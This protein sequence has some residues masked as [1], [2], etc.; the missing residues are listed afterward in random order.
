MSN[1]S[2]I[3]LCT[4]IGIFIITVGLLREDKE[5]RRE[6]LDSMRQAVD[7]AN[8]AIRIMNEQN[9]TFEADGVQVDPLEDGRVKATFS[10][11]VGKPI[12]GDGETVTAKFRSV[13]MPA[14]IFHQ[15]IAE[16]S[17]K[18]SFEALEKREKAI[19]EREEKS[20]AVE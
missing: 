6:M 7:S 11:V 15:V 3:A 2:A 13:I 19:K 16:G 5:N 17:L 20:G 10:K 14:W 18:S 8:E 9:L 1:W 4:A 12:E